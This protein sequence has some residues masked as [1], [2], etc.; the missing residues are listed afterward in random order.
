M[1]D[2][3]FELVEQEWSYFVDADKVETRPQILDISPTKGSFPAL[4]NRLNLH[5]IDAI[6]TKIRLQRN[7]VNKS[8]HVNGKIS[9]DISQKC[10]ITTDSVV[11]HIETEFNAWFSEP[12]QTVSFAKAKRERL[13]PKEQN[14]QPIL[15]ENDDPEEVINGKIDLGELVAQYLSLALDPYPR[16][17]GACFDEVEKPLKDSAEEGVFDN[18]FA[19]LKNWKHKETKK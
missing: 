4:C 16:K 10:V 3:E 1:S 5:S 17:E 13:S 18:P 11:E 2:S 15:E 9:A 6:N 8:I 12:N 19:A 14:E 7:S